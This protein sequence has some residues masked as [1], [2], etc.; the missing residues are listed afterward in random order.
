[1]KAAEILRKLADLIDTISAEESNTVTGNQSDTQSIEGQAQVNVKTMVPPL[2]QKLD[3][4]KKIAGEESCD[5]CSSNPCVCGYDEL[6][7]IKQNA[8]IEPAFV[9]VSADEDE[10]FEG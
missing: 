9:V 7:I 6:A 2:Q 1:M 5:A 8:G 3:L 10:P 4:M